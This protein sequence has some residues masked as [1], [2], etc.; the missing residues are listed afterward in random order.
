MLVP[1]TKTPTPV[2][3]RHIRDN[4]LHAHRRQL[5]RLVSLARKVET[6]HADDIAAPHGLT[7]ALEAISQALDAH[8]DH[9]E[10]VVFP[11]LKRGHAGRVQD[12]LAGLRDDH[13]DHEAALNRIAAMTHGFRLPRSACPFWRQLYAGLGRL[14]EDLD[15]HR[16]LENELLFP[17]FE[18]PVR[19]G[20]ADPT[21]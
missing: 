19:P 6:R 7:A 3:L 9:E 15:E 16:Y 2:L 14:A 17:R 20:P 4:I 8:I 1:D 11:A 10:A 18:T 13:A 21:R 12:A 5:P